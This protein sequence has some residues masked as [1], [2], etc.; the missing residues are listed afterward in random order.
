[1]REERPSRECGVQGGEVDK[2]ACPATGG[3]GGRVKNSVIEAWPGLGC[4][5]SAVTVTAQ[6]AT[7]RSDGQQTELSVA[8]T[9][10]QAMLVVWL[11]RAMHSVVPAA[12]D[13]VQWVVSVGGHCRKDATG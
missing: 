5:L 2:R 1:M 8:V 4:G 3:E 11:A 7:G 6:C 13:V 9:N 10:T 12:N